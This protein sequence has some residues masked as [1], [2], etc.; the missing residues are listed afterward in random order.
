MYD[1]PSEA[2]A[3]E[4]GVTPGHLRRRRLRAE[5]YIA[6]AAEDQPIFELEVA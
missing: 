5:A 4:A 6:E 2:I 1:V 3:A